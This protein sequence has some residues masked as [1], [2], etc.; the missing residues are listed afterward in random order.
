[1]RGVIVASV[2]ID[3][4][5]SFRGL[6]RRHWQCGPAESL[7]SAPPAAEALESALARPA[8]EPGGSAPYDA[9]IYHTIILM[10]NYY[11]VLDLMYT[12]I[13]YNIL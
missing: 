4:G 9:M 12:I 6:C 2:Q 3:S 1:M 11:N 7:R 10:L 8:S 5:G 13:Y